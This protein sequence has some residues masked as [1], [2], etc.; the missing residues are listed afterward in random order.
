MRADE[1]VLIGQITRPHGVRG[2]VRVRP[3]TESPASFA[4]Y[5]RLYLRVPGR[6]EKD[7]QVKEVR[8]HKTVVL[9][10][11]KG[12]RTREQAEALRGAGVYIRRDWLPRL[13]A[14]EYYWKDLIGLSAYDEAGRCLG[15]VENIFTAGEVEILVI[16]DGRRETLAPFRAE[17]ILQVDVDQRRLLIKALE[18]LNDG[19]TGD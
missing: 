7:Y 8:P 15:R 4:R 17:V 10:K 5:D 16:T 12:I 18:G 14:D 6:A 13:P 1:L 3:F 11:L 19:A 9:L 2:E